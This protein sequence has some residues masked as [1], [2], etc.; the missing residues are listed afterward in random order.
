[1][2]K[3]GVPPAQLS[4]SQLLERV[5]DHRDDAAFEVLYARHARL[6][7]SCSLRIL[8]DRG[9]AAD[10]VQAAFLDVWRASASYS[11]Q[12]GAVGAWIAGITAN[13]ST[14]ILRRAHTQERVTEAIVAGPRPRP[15]LDSVGD[16]AIEA[17]RCERWRAE[18]EALP[19]SQRE[20][21]V[22]AYYG[23]LSHSEI[24]SRLEVPLGTVKSRVRLGLGRLRDQVACNAERA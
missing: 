14:D 5:R 1:M 6:A 18:I 3:H 7:M 19:E 9:M 13:R 20:A 15:E 2:N 17:D 22:L 4:D 10:A 24:A 11:P 21:V 8:F 16:S 23:D 12:R